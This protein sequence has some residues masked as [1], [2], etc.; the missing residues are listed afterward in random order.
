MPGTKRTIAYLEG[1]FQTGDIPTQ[2][3]FYDLFA[4]F[5][6]YQQLLTGGGSS[7]EIPMSQNAVT[8]FVQDFLGNYAAASGTDTYTASLSPAITAYVKGQVFLLTDVTAN[9]V[10]N[11]TVAL[12]GLAAKNLLDYKGNA[13]TV[14]VFA[15]AVIIGYDGTAFRMLGGGGGGG[16]ISDTVY[17]SGWNGDTTNGASK[18]ALYDKIETL[19]P[20]ASPALTGN[21]TAPTASPGDGDTS[22]ATTAFVQQEL[23]NNKLFLYYNFF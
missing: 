13:L 15:G 1:K 12:N 10:T 5:I 17:G 18:N 3:D 11:P 2:T 22:I 23:V 7:T 14:G 6:H 8:R 21:P 4:S 16:S 20:L 9:T 19:A